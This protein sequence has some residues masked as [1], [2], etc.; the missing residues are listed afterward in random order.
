MN[1]NSDDSIHDI[2]ERLRKNVE[3]QDDEP[4]AETVAPAPN[5]ESPENLLDKLKAHMGEAAA[6]TE[7][8]RESDYDIRGFEISE[9]EE[10]EMP[11]SKEE[12]QPPQAEMTES[13]SK[14]ESLIDLPWEEG[15]ESAPSLSESS[16][17]FEEAE[18]GR[19]N[20]DEETEFHKDEQVEAPTETISSS[21]I[22]EE[23]IAE[24]SLPPEAEELTE[25]PIDCA[26]T[27]ELQE[28]EPIEEN[29]DELADTK[30]LNDAENHADV[31]TDVVANAEDD[32][33][34]LPS[35][36]ADSDTSER[37]MSANDIET[38]EES[39]NGERTTVVNTSDT[40]EDAKEN[41]TVDEQPL[42][43]AEMEEEV[44]K[45]V[46]LFVEKTVAPE[47]EFDYF[48]QMERAAMRSK[49]RSSSEESI[50]TEAVSADITD[51]VQE[52]L[53][54]ETDSE[55]T[56][57]L[58]SEVETT[59]P[60]EQESQTMVEAPISAEAFSV[61]SENE[62][63]I[64]SPL[65]ET[66]T[67]SFFYQKKDTDAS[68][69][70]S[71]SVDHAASR[72]DDT[73]INLLLALGQKD[74]LEKSVGFVRVREAKNNFYDPAD[75]EPIGKAFAYSG[76]EFRSSEQA[77]TIKS[78][79]RKERKTLYKRLVC[80]SLL[81]LVLLFL[82][83][84]T[85]TGLTIPYLSDFLSVKLYYNLT[86]LVLITLCLLISLKPILNGIHGFF[87]MRPNQHTPVAV[88]SLLNLVYSIALPLFFNSS[89]I[90]TYNFVL[91]L[92]WILSIIG[93]NIRLTK[94]IMTFDVISDKK[95][96]FSLEK[97]ELSP[98]TIREKNVL[99]KR[100][101]LVERVSFVGKYFTRTARRSAAYNQ[102]FIE[103]LV[104]LTVAILSAVV[105]AFVSNSV[106]QSVH[107]LILVLFIC[108]PAQHLVLGV[109]PFGRLAKL[110]YKNDSAII[111]ETVDREYVGANT[112]YLDDIE[113]FGHH[114]VS[115]SGLRVYN[116]A[117]LC[118]ILYHASAVFSQVEGPLRY[119]FEDSA[120]EIED[121]QS[122]KLLNICANGVEALVDSQD[123]IFIGNI[124]FMRSNGFFPK[125]NEDDDRKVDSGEIS[126]LYMTVNGTL[127]AKFY[128]KYVITQRFEKFVEEM[129]ENNTKVG[130]RTLDPNVT[131]R[132]IAL[133]RR[134]KET[135]ISVI[136]P[137]LNDLTPLG[138]RSDS[139]IITAKSP[140]MISRILAQCTRLKKINRFSSWMRFLSGV[141]GI[142]AIVALI[143]TQMTNNVPSLAVAFYQLLW[144][145][146]T[147]IY[148]KIKLK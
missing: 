106:S 2:L 61:L 143:L 147:L 131:E 135:E 48:A 122:V 12:K 38:D 75:E 22:I 7:D 71:L 60:I 109:Y 66:K 91:S 58:V 10:P 117:D 26:E 113:M 138:R 141:V 54:D 97:A 100:D 119:V 50:D 30:P 142:G 121:P 43:T 55:N 25:S 68:S 146:P 53:P 67:S 93:D 114:G 52:T 44:R 81:S 90:N 24:A 32:V 56:D 140:H 130:I 27:E 144:L 136:R 21:A 96:K 20:D 57:I 18:N 98:E 49:Q 8:S 1:R 5:T 51:P 39:D 62:E 86:N 89:N 137:T 40:V 95:E 23:V 33:V 46:E 19:G 116:D 134:G 13:S 77:E 47:E 65:L 105:T 14:Q 69:K 85:L 37:E 94:E 63:T 15:P 148:T 59:P 84:L 127:C 107:M 6:S 83:H 125:R 87:T 120:Q 29:S 88:L 64:A 11:S 79:Y 99:Q 124:G 115:V 133:L 108:I 102:Y 36:S 41:E 139:G 4:I 78:N 82:E 34:E 42:T 103:L 110:L 126:I 132:M 17:L 72:L 118:K 128:M 73:D 111:G 9:S 31:V 45:R 16:D 104:I 76:E 92:F 101:L 112:V 3:N 35:V 70:D 123:K 74:A 145:I 28:S 129:S 80:T